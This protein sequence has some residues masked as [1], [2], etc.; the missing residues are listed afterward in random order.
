MLIVG[1]TSAFLERSSTSRVRE[2]EN[3]TK[4]KQAT[5]EKPKSEYS[6]C[7]VCHNKRPKF[8]S[9]TDFFTYLE[10]YEATEGFSQI[11]FLSEGGFGSV[12]RGKLKNGQK[13]AV[14]QLKAAS[15]QGEKEFKSEVKVLSQARHQNLVMLLGSCAKGSHRLLVYEYICNRSLEEHLSG[16]I[17]LNCHC[18]FY[19]FHCKFFFP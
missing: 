19:S 14:K 11:N 6:I 2:T 4:L 12:Y 17:Y 5:A 3:D 10:L 16:T 13:I 15:L 7:S 18:N 9:Q 8:G 1:S